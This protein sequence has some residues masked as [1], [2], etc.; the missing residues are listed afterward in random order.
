MALLPRAPWLCY[1]GSVPSGR[2]TMLPLANVRVLDF[3]TLLPGPFAT[4][5]LAEA[6]AEVIKIERPGGEDMR[7]GRPRAGDQGL[8]FAM[9]NR[10]KKS[11]ELDLKAPGAAARLRPLIESADVLVE[12]FRPGV[13]ARLGLDWDAVRAMNPGLVYCAI[14]G[15]GQSGPKALTAGHD[16]NYCAETG[17]LSMTRGA[18]GKPNIPQTQIA[19]IGAGSYPAVMNIMF[20]LWG[21]QR[22]GKGAYL[23]ISMCDN[24][25]P[26]LWAPLAMGRATGAWPEGN[27][28]YLTGG[29]PRYQIYRTRDDKFIACGALEQKFWDNFCDCIG[30]DET[31]R[32]DSK[33]PEATLAGVTACIAARDAAEWEAAFAGRDVCAVPVRSLEEALTDPQFSERGLFTHML[34]AGDSSLPALSVPVAGSLRGVSRGA[35]APALGAANPLLAEPLAAE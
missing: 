29:T 10:G 13:M 12:Q 15:Y 6:G 32:D 9:L 16:L 35:G 2:M 19:D 33:D 27:D 11:I 4:L 28:M 5:I 25:F 18:D 7:A 20:A 17:F 24:L 30:L 1:R 31:L 8:L 21:A 22:T 23:D 34:Q 26:L 3:T 14:T